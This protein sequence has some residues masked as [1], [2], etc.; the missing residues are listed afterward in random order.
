MGIIAT[1]DALEYH[2]NGVCGEPFYA[3]LFTAE[4]DIPDDPNRCREA[5]FLG[6]VFDEP[7]QCAV[8]CLDKIDTHGVEFGEG[9][10][11][12]RGDLYE[13]AL[14]NAIRKREASFNAPN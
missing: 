13:P 14:R 12:W 4:A 3:A 8:I 7:G 10:N 2:R 1:L 6:I 5:R 9:G 11:S